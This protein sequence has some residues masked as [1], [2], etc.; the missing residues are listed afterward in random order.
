MTK[1][2]DPL[3]KVLE[4][5]P[6]SGWLTDSDENIIYMNDAM[7]ELFGDLTGQKTDMVYDCGSFEI[8]SQAMHEGAGV[9]EIVISDVPF[10]RFSST[11]DLGEDGRY[12]VEHFEDVSE[13]AQMNAK[14]KKALARVSAGAKMAK[15]IQ[16][17]I[18]PINDT[19]WDTIAYNSF[20]KPADD[21]GGDFHDLMKLSD[22]EYLVYIADVS[23]HGIRSALLT[24]FM[25]ERVRMNMAAAF[26]GPGALLAELVQDFSKVDTEGMMYVTMVIC[27]YTKSR[28]ELAISN[29]G[30]NCYP[31]IV[32]NSGR[33][34]AIP[35]HG[36]P[37]CSIAEGID[38][39]EE[40]VS[41]H[42][43]DR[44]VLFTDGVIEEVDKA[45]GRSFGLEG[46]RGLAEKYGEYNGSYLAQ[47]IMEESDH[48]SLIKAKDDRTIVVADFLS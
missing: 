4:D 39:D 44:L 43:G 3:I 2:I 21:L 47:K 24:V 9:S 25:R 36:M 23:G 13:Q 35:T 33:S 30:H 29:A 11:V 20:Y 38:Y 34:E 31:L 5:F 37:I 28:R 22:D 14:M 8:V 7:K 12:L 17:S 27:K 46:V 45:T 16:Q 32:R 48:Y 42:P 19:Y 6:I 10:H 15:T 41:I 1:R 26:E 40:V 18:L